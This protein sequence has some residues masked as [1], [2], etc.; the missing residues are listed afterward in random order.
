MRPG[1]GH[2]RPPE[3]EFADVATVEQRQRDIKA[4]YRWHALNTARPAALQHLLLD[5]VREKLG[6]VLR[7][8]MKAMLGPPIEPDEAASLIAQLTR[9]TS[10]PYQAAD[11]R[12]RALQR[13]RQS[14]PEYR[15]ARR[16]RDQRNRGRASWSI[17]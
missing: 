3:P 11:E 13:K 17:I 14:T 9:G 15:E 12:R 2:N 6:P 8:V 1:I 16:L 4:F 10:T 7:K 5:E